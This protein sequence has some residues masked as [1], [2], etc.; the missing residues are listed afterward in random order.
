MVRGGK[1]ARGPCVAAAACT[2]FRALAQQRRLGVRARSLGAVCRYN[3]HVRACGRL[4]A[5]MGLVRACHC[6]GP[7]ELSNWRLRAAFGEAGTR[8]TR[9]PAAAAAPAAAG[10]MRWRGLAARARGRC[11]AG[12]EAPLRPRRRWRRH[13]RECTGARPAKH[14]ASAVGLR[15]GARG[16]ASRGAPW[17]RVL[18]ARP[19]HFRLPCAAGLKPRKRHADSPREATQ[20]ARRG[21][22]LRGGEGHGDTRGPPRGASGCCRNR[23]A[24]RPHE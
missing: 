19:L 18:A 12:L 4:L 20:R 5:A 9:R 7:R 15:G 6:Y 17:G 2:R 22:P 10:G 8:P 13:P 21:R 1:R 23:P 11:R 14:V 3:A 16:E 24:Q